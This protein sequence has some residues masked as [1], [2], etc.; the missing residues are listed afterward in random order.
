MTAIL[1]PREG[2]PYLDP[3]EIIRRLEDEFEVC[4]TDAEAGQEHA[5]DM[6]AKLIELKAPQ[7]IIDEV[8]N[9]R[10]RAKMVLIADDPTT[11][12]YLDFLVRP[13]AHIV[14]AHYSGQHEDATRPLLTRC[15]RALGYVIYG[16]EDE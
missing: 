8:V 9:G 14:I 2:S 1:N 11:E 16:E 13:N 12:D 7:D 10:D 4:N 3:E 5:G 15:A 6:L